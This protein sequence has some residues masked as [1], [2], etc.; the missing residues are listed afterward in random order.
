MINL[1]DIGL[2]KTNLQDKILC[3]GDLQSGNQ[4]HENSR[5][6]LIAACD[7]KR[8]FHYEN[9]L[10]K[11]GFTPFFMPQIHTERK[12]S[13]ICAELLDGLLL[14]GGG[15]LHPAHFNQ[16]DCGSREIETAADRMQFHLA[17]AFLNAGK[18]ILGICKGMQVLN[19]LFGGDL[20][21]DLPSEQKNIHA[22]NTEQKKDRIH[23][24]FLSVEYPPTAVLNPQMLQKIPLQINSAHH[25]AVNNLGHGLKAIQWA[26]D[27]IVEGIY[28]PEMPITGLQWHPERC[29]TPEAGLLFQ[30]I[31]KFL[32]DVSSK[33]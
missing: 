18:P 29:G 13:V 20:Y 15:D 25:Q 16:T 14:P 8:F 4:H 26:N 5:R 1:Q 21:Q 9:A 3:D 19:V 10:K 7:R 22:Y 12:F 33:T 11:A 24:S 27:G 31:W 23:G 30:E 28:H 17:E 2:Q 32:F 6:I